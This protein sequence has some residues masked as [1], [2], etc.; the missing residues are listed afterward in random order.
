MCHTWKLKKVNILPFS[1]LIYP[2]MGRKIKIPASC[3]FLYSFEEHSCA[4]RTLYY[5]NCRRSSRKYE[6][7]YLPQKGVMGVK[8]EKSGFLRFLV[9]VR[10][11]HSSNYNNLLLKLKEEFEKMFQVQNRLFTP[12]M[13]WTG[14][15]NQNPA[16]CVFLYPYGI[17]PRSWVILGLRKIINIKSWIKAW[18]VL[19]WKRAVI[20]RSSFLAALD[21]W[22]RLTWSV[23]ADRRHPHPTPESSWWPAW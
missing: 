10:K 17:S 15:R 5:Q 13:G 7:T 16:S 22:G 18:V 4:M 1:G 3:V 11:A 2:L 12:K 23:R 9:W 8:N 21:L 20:L 6:I 14:R 19:T